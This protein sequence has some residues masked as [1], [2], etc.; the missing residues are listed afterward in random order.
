MV[1]LVTPKP[2]MFQRIK[3]RGVVKSK[4]QARTKPLPA[5]KGQ[6]GGSCNRSHC[7]RPGATWWNH[8]SYAYYCASCAYELNEDSF[9]KREA[10]QMYG[11]KLCTNGKYDKNWDYV[12][13]KPKEE[14][15]QE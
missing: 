2:N 7:L 9:N 10:M 15:K 5:D 3:A 14:V 6:F 11:H 12:N 13:N 8:G 4:I 1:K